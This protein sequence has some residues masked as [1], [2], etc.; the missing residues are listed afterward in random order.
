MIEPANSG[1]VIGGTPFSAVAR[2]LIV[3][4]FVVVV[5]LFVRHIGTIVWPFMWALL[6]AYIV[7]PLVNFLNQELRVP[8]FLVVVGLLLVLACVIIVGSRYLIPWLQDQ[9]TYFAQD[10]PKLT[11]SLMSKV[12]PRPLGIDIT[13]VELQLANRLNGSTSSPNASIRLLSVAFSITLRILLFLFTTIYLLLDGPRIRRNIPRLVPVAYRPEASQLASRINSTW[14][15]YIRGELILF[16]IMTVVSFIGLTIL[17]VPGAVPLAIATGALELLPIVGPF[18]AGALAVS[19]A[20]LNGTN[21]FGWSQI[22]YGIVVAVMYLGFRETE[23]YVVIPRVLGHA[24]RLHPLVI[25]F[26]LAASGI[27]AGLFG[28]LVAVPIAAS[29]KIVGAYLYDKVV[30]QRPE[31]VG[32]HGVGGDPPVR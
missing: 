14:M 12:G 19:V 13:R 24:V 2:W 15:S 30:T 6:V 17:Q 3:V 29:L 20:Y 11:G 18:T 7:M 10:L 4:G 23:D 5:Y 9:L 27:L 1:E 21:P 26:S 28:L 32:V 31:F 22:T 16:G 8:R 25:L